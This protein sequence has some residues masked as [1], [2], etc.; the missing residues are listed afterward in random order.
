MSWITL[1]PTDLE[2]YVAAA[3]LKALQTKALGSTQVDPLPEYLAQAATRVRMAIASAGG[4]LQA[5]PNSVPAS[6]RATVA[7]L[8][9]EQAHTRLVGLALTRE[10]LA[11]ASQ[12]RATLSLLSSGKLAYE[13]PDEP[14]QSIPTQSSQIR[15]VKRRATPPQAN[16]L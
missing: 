6:L 7:A 8:A 5:T 4:L 13:A 1:N 3:Q 11:Q 9:L 14:T 2:Q 12:A 15:V 16:E 10:Q